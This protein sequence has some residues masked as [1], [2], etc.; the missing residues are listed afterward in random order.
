MI[1][2]GNVNQPDDTEPGDD[3]QPGDG[4]GD[5]DEGTQDPAS[6]TE[7]GGPL[8]GQPSTGPQGGTTVTTAQ[9]LPPNPA[10]SRVVLPQ[11]G[12]AG[13]LLAWSLAG[14]VLLAAGL[15]LTRRAPGRRTAG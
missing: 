14:L 2:S 13:G 6:T 3:P 10:T 12:T 5:G 4:N 7:S 8:S 1:G 15:L 9:G 11:T